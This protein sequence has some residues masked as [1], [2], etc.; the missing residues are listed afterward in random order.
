[1]TRPFVFL[2]R[3]GT[4][5]RDH[6]YTHKL[7]DYE[8]LPGVQQGLLRMRQGGFSLAVVTNQSGIG[9]GYYAEADLQAFQAHLFADLARSGIRFERTFFCPHLPEAGCTCRKPAPGLLWRAREELGADLGASWVVGDRASDVE[10]AQRAGC[11]GAVLI[12]VNATRK[13][14]EVPTV[15]DLEEAAE[16][17]LSR[18]AQPEGGGPA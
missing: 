15:R 3:D 14:G 7:A 18:D 9:R 5:I 16:F 1:V 13:L 6:G 11:R 4:L 10:L 17:I 8:L 12:G 2:D